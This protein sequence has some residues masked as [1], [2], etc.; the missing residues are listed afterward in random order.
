MKPTNAT[1][2]ELLKNKR[3]LALA[4]RGHK[5]LKDKLDGLIQKFLS[6]VKEYDEYQKELMPYLKEIFSQATIVTAKMSPTDFKFSIANSKLA[7]VEVK[8]KNL[9]GTKVPTYNIKSFPAPNYG[10]SSSLELDQVYLTL[11]KA[12]EK[13]FKMA[14]LYQSIQIMGKQIVE[15]KRRVNALEFILIPEIETA[16]KYISMKLGEM[17]REERVVLMKIK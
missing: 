17:E 9:L 16:V 11:K 3:R 12:S 10:L 6:I 15:T 7:E 2:M 1:R 13:I 8:T 5:L 14:S 4:K